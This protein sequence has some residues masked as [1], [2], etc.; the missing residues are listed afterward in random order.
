MS[1]QSNPIQLVTSAAVGRKRSTKQ[2]AY[3]APAKSKR[4]ALEVVMSAQ[5]E[6]R[7]KQEERRTVILG[8]EEDPTSV[9]IV[10]GDMLFREGLKR[11]LH[12]APFQI[13]GEAEQLADLGQAKVAGVDPDIVI[14]VDAPIDPKAEWVGEIRKIWND[15][16]VVMLSNGADDASLSG[17][18]RAGA[19]GC[20][21]KDMSPAALMQAI[22]LVALGENVAP[23]RMVRNLA[24]GGGHRA[25][26]AGE[27]RLT[28][29][30]KDIL[31]GLLAGQS[32]KVIANS[33]GTTDMTVKAQLRHLLRKI[34][35]S[36][37]TQAALWA[38]ENGIDR[39]LE[40]EEEEA[41][42]CH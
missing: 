2:S 8:A 29:R 34:G 26:T 6:N 25:A 1:L 17:A 30:E 40:K 18:L 5:S 12:S 39:E 35:V 33:L 9:V 36:N 4:A 37:R 22:N 23:L 19:D 10:G 14:V 27:A 3:D 42:K 31:Q 11:L 38:R 21:F 16:R 32:N 24:G 13:D 28:A 15:T 20:L 7:Q 41:R